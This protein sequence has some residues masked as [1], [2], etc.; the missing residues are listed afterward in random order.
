MENEALGASIQ[1]VGLDVHK[2]SASATGPVIR[3][4]GRLV[5]SRAR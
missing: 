2:D 5:P 1:Y 4:R 3:R